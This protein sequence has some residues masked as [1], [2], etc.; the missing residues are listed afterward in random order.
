MPHRLYYTDVTDANIN[1]GSVNGYTNHYIA[2]HNNY[3]ATGSSSREFEATATFKTKDGKTHTLKHW[4]TLGPE[5]RYKDP[6]RIDI[7]VSDVY[8]GLSQGAPSWL[9]TLKPVGDEENL[10]RITRAVYKLPETYSNPTITVPATADVRG[11][12]LGMEMLAFSR[13]PVEVT[14]HYDDETT[15]TFNVTATTSASANESIALFSSWWDA[16]GRLMIEPAGPRN[17]VLNLSS[18]EYRYRNKGRWYRDVIAPGYHRNR[19]LLRVSNRVEL[20]VD[21]VGFLKT[22]DG[23]TQVAEARMAIKHKEPWGNMPLLS[24]RGRERFWGYSKEGRPEW[25]VS[26]QVVGATSFTDKIQS[27]TYEGNTRGA[28]TEPFK[29]VM[30]NNQEL[31]LLKSRPVAVRAL[32]TF[33]PESNL[34]PMRVYG[35]LPTTSARTAKPVE[36]ASARLSVSATQHRWLVHLT[37]WE[38]QLREV[39]SV[40]YSTAGQD[41]ANQVKVEQRQG[42]YPEFGF[43]VGTTGP[44]RVDALVRFKDGREESLSIVV[45]QPIPQIDYVTQTRYWGPMSRLAGADARGDAFETTARL[46]GDIYDMRSVRETTLRFANPFDQVVNVGLPLHTGRRVSAGVG[47]ME[48]VDLYMLREKKRLPGRKLTAPEKYHRELTLLFEPGPV[49]AGGAAAAGSDADKAAPKTAGPAEYIAYLA[50]PEMD[51]TNVT[52]VDYKFDFAGTQREQRV[53]DR[54]GEFHEGY[55]ARIVDQ[56]VSGIT[57]TVRFN[58][59]TK[60]TVTWTR[61]AGPTRQP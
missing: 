52:Y 55:E 30:E 1:A 29:Y 53:F 4:V 47:E 41:R 3:Q 56:G 28:T 51:L 42:N 32:V 50:G 11:G 60:Q 58:D 31:A 44:T 39:E 36:L 27:V 33:K 9:V 7:D 57:A 20:P 22:A 23:W 46:V 2:T 13:Q 16:W 48:F 43:A 21:V 5:A 59:G 26:L 17:T 19:G 37:G 40:T 34:A 10:K 38:M 45:G 25:I 8:E 14:V 6:R 15:S 12:K 61:P 49:P 54:W 18:A 35:W 24:L